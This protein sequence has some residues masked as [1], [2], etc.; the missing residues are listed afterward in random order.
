MLAD[1][2]QKFDTLYVS[3]LTRATQ[4]ADII[5]AGMGLRSVTL[6]SLREIDLYSFQVSQACRNGSSSSS[7]GGMGL[8][9]VMLPSLH[10]IFCA[11]SRCV[12]DSSSS[13]SSSGGM[14]LRS[15]T[16]PS[17]REIDLYSFQVSQVNSSSSSSGG[18]GLRSVT[19]P[20]LRKIDLYLS[21]VS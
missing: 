7:S 18:T 1:D 2:V 5:T 10:E 20:S 9:S 8:R 13:S 19:L 11:R 15:V 3:P 21:Q 16:L 6:P 4:T 14:G 12:S 17:L